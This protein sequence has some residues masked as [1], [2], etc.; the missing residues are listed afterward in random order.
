VEVTVTGLY[1]YPVKSCAGVGLHQCSFTT[2]GLTGD[3][4]WVIID[5]EGLFISQRKYPRMALIRVK[6]TSLGEL[7]LH[8]TGEDFK[9]A[10]CPVPMPHENAPPEKVRIWKDQAPARFASEDVGRWISK[11]LQTDEKLTLAQ[12]Y[13]G[14]VRA[15]GQPKRFGPNT[16]NF[17]DAAPFLIVNSLSLHMLNL[18]LEL[19]KLPEIDI[20]HFRPNIVVSGLPGFAEHHIKSLRH[21][22][23]GAEFSLVDPCQ[24]CSVITVNPDTGERMP[25]LVPFKQLTQLNP[26]P[27]NAKAPAFGMNA[28]LSSGTN[29]ITASVGLRL[30][31]KLQV[32]Q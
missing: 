31:D 19:Q 20:R 17:A 26:M 2:R 8:Y 4:E 28:I 27:D 13:R 6:R 21:I 7:T 29:A 32:I 30:G 18:S 3:R 16:T 1:H 12:F 11:V 24:R 22:T 10:P 5:K 15:P 23:S 25:D 9:V 14:G